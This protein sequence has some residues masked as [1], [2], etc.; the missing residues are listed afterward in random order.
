M[1]DN[2]NSGT[3]P[4]DFAMNINEVQVLGRVSREPKTKGDKIAVPIVVPTWKKGGGRQWVPF[5]ID[6]V[7]DARGRAKELVP[8]DYFQCTARF[9]QRK[10]LEDDNGDKKS[11]LVLQM[12]PYRDVT[13]RPGA[14]GDDYDAMNPPLDDVCFTR[15]ILA[16]R[17]FIRKKQIDDG[18]GNTPILR[19]GN[20][21]KYCF[22]TMTYEDPYQQ[23]PEGQWPESIY[24]DL[25]LSGKTAEIV[26]EHCR[27]RAQVHVIGELSKREAG[28]TINGRTPMEPRVS[29]LLGGFKFV[30]LDRG[31][32]SGAAKTPESAQ[33]YEDGDTSGIDGLDDDLPF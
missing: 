11:I 3:K 6:V 31:G 24:I 25:S 7:G 8:G 15:V 27:A 21:G 18:K 12:D 20:T 4:R 22:V 28:F 1:S 30:N 17:N 26:S 9:V 5:T 10:G 2:D 32:S 16:G 13:F 19:E 33:S 23:V 29:P 14:V